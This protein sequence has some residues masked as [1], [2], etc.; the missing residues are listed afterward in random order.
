MITNDFDKAWID[1]HKSITDLDEYSD[2][3]RIMSYISIIDSTLKQLE[4]YLDKEYHWK[5]RN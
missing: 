2:D 4:K 1:L 5:L 3:E